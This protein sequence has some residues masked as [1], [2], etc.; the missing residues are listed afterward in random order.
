MHQPQ[1]SSY[2]GLVQSLLVSPSG[3]ENKILQANQDLLDL[4]LV[5]VMKKIAKFNR[6]IDGLHAQWLEN[7]AAILEINLKN[8]SLSVDEKKYIIFLMQVLQIISDND[9]KLENI[10]S[11][12]EY[13]QDLL[14]K[15]FLKVIQ[16]WAGEN[17]PK[18]EQ[19]LA[20]NIAL[21]IISFS[22]LILQF[23]LGNQSNNVEIAIAGYEV[24]LKVLSCQE[25]PEIW[26]TIQ[27][28]L[29]SSYQKRTIG[30]LEENIEVAIACYDK[31]L[32]VRTNSALPETWATTQNNLGNAY[33]QR[34]AGR[35]KENLENAI[36]CYQKALTVRRLE[37]L[38]QEWATTLNN[39]GSAY[40]ERIAGEKKENIEVAIAC[41][42]FALKVRTKEQ[43]PLDWATTQNNLGNVY[44]DRM[45]GDKQN[46]LKQAIACFVRAQEVYTQESYPVYWEIIS[47]NLSMVYDERR[48]RQ[49]S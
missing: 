4:G 25:F 12:L 46:N 18:M 49:V 21:D 3:N 17:L 1:I 27:N 34:I 37:K 15:N 35:R 22:N 10:Y 32:E 16:T 26:G 5:Q 29:G 6:K 30:N 23:P 7:L 39:L 44:L 13:N 47:H 9:V 33:Q 28:N 48:L 38:P 14:N 40:H 8:I 31:A 11:L 41:Y 20:Q 19:K 36:S 42:I 43:F 2:I 24:A 45:M